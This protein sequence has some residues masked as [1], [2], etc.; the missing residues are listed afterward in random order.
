MN[1][2]LASTMLATPFF[3]ATASFADVT[4]YWWQDAD[5]WNFKRSHMPDLD[6]RRDDCCE[7]PGLPGD[8]S[9]YGV[10]TSMMN[11]LCYPSNHGIP[12]LSPGSGNWQWN[13]LYGDAT[14][15]I[16]E[17]GGYMATD[18]TMGTSGEGW[19]GGSGH[20]LFLYGAGLLAR[21]TSYNELNNDP[22]VRGMTLKNFNGGIT[23]FCYGRYMNGGVYEDVPLLGT[24]TGG[25]CVSFVGS[26]KG[27]TEFW[28]RYRDPA[29][30]GTNATQSTFVTKQVGIIRVQMA[31]VPDDD[32]VK[33]VDVLVTGA[34]DGLLRVID[35]YV[36]LTP[37]YFLTF[38]NNGGTLSLN[39]VA[40]LAMGSV[41]ELIPV[42]DAS[43]IIDMDLELADANALVLVETTP[44]VRQ[45]RR[46]NLVD[47]S[48]T[49][50]P[51]PDLAGIVTGRDGR[52][53]AHDGNKLYCLRPD[54][55]IEAAQ[56]QI[57]TPSALAYDDENDHVVL[58][59]VA[60]R[61]IVRLTKSLQT[62]STYTV[63]PGL[64]MLGEG[65]VF[66]NPAD[67]HVFFI[68]AASSKIAEV[69]GTSQ[70]FVLTQHTVLGMPFPKS[71]GGNDIGQ[72]FVATVGGLRV[73][74]PVQGGWVVD[75][76]SPFHDLEITGRMTNL[77]SRSN[78]NPQ[79]HVG[80]A[81]DTIPADE[82]IEFGEVIPDCIGD[83]DSDDDVDGADLGDLLGAWGF[84]DPAADLDGNG[85]VDG[86][87]LGTL[88]GS[89]GPCP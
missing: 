84:N 36:T 67:Q 25:H 29:S 37:I 9:G 22:S 50:L 64:P 66:V 39:Q 86:S 21:T 34:S 4:V 70:P 53:Y 28:V 6:Q 88:L 12:L 60:T 14:D 23:A 35:G 16:A 52:I 73:L 48:F 3:C 65:S 49:A 74:N 41:T 10:P 8:G 27:E 87:D 7:S 83:L 46:Y 58:L 18:P 77:Y 38:Q 13:G 68:T 56:S 82:L 78:F 1:R 89:W 51:F 24:R 33:W 30:D 11:L 40:P 5:H 57:P 59:S 26:A 81:W 15:A 55:S 54:G 20:W 42:P 2:T 80:P 71:I 63:P 32:W 79:F 17:L 72:L 31:Y 43:A 76:Q 44:G 19:S 69:A 62:F 75:T 45:L 61:K 85:V 47:G